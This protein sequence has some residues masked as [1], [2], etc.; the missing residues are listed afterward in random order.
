MGPPITSFSLAPDMGL[1]AT[2]HTQRRGVYLWAN[3]TIFGSGDNAPKLTGETADARMP[4]LTAGKPS[5]PEPVLKVNGVNGPPCHGWLEAQPA[6]MGKCWLSR[7]DCQG[8]PSSPS[9]RVS[10]L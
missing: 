1:L 8:P 9:S 2:A 6:S 3:Q 4:A 5:G 7:T 10:L